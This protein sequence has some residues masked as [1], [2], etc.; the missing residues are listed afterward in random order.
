MVIRVRSSKIV[1][2]QLPAIVHRPRL[3]QFIRKNRHKRLIV[4]QGQAAQGKSTLAASCVQTILPETV[5]VNLD[6]EDSDAS[7]LFHVLVHAFKH[8]MEWLDISKLLSCPAIDM[9]PRKPQLRYREWAHVMFD[10]MP[11]PLYIVLDGLDRLADNGS[12]LILLQELLV[13]APEHV[14]FILLSREEPSLEIQKIRVAQQAAVLHNE[15]LAFNFD[16]IRFFF[17]QLNSFDLSFD[18]LKRIHQITEGWAGGVVLISEHLDHL[19]VKDRHTYLLRQ[20]PIRF[21]EAVFQYFLEEVLCSQPAG[22][23]EFLVR[24]SVFDIIE[25]KLVEHVLKIEACQEFLLELNRK[26]LF[27]HSRFDEE[28]G[29]E[30]Q[31]HQLFKEFLQ[32]KFQVQVTDEQKYK[33]YLNSGVFFEE[34]GDYQK[35]IDFYILAHEYGKAAACIE[36]IGMKLLENGRNA[37]LVR[38]LEALPENR[39]DRHPWLVYFQCMAHRFTG[40][41]E[42][43]ER[44][45]TVMAAFRE[46][47]S[48]KGEIQSLSAMLEAVIAA[49]LGWHVLEMYLDQAEQLLAAVPADVRPHEKAFLLSQYGYGHTVRGNLQTG[50]SALEEAFSLAWNFGNQVLQIT[51]ACHMVVNLTAQNKLFSAQKY[52]DMLDNLVKDIVMPEPQV[53]NL[54]AKSILASFRGEASTARQLL[55]SADRQVH[56]HGLTYYLPVVL[57]YRVF[58]CVICNRHAEMN[59]VGNQLFS[60]ANAMENQVMTASAAFFLGL[61]A[62]RSQDFETASRFLAQADRLCSPGETNTQIQWYA[63]KVVGCLVD[64]SQGKTKCRENEIHDALAYF[65]KEACVCLVAETYMAL[66]LIE[67]RRKREDP[68]KKYLSR[69]FEMSLHAEYH[70]FLVL[71]RTDI[72]A[73]C[74]SAL[75]LASRKIQRHAAAFFCQQPADMRIS[76]LE[77]RAAVLWARGDFRMLDQMIATLPVNIREGSPHLIF[78]Q[79]MCRLPVAPEIAM[80]RLIQALDMFEFQGDPDGCFLAVAGVLN[81]VFCQFNGFRNL[82]RILEKADQLEIRFGRPGRPEVEVTLTGAVLHALI[83]RDPVSDTARKWIG[84]GWQVTRQ[85]KDIHHAAPVFLP[86]IL[87]R[88]LQG[89]L[90]GAG[91]LLKRFDTVTPER[92]SP[93]LCLMLQSLKAFHAWLSGDFDAGLQAVEQGLAREKETGI[94]LIFSSFRIQGAASAIGAGRYELAQRFLDQI[95]PVVAHQGMW[96]QGWYHFVCAWLALVTGNSGACRLHASAGFEK[97]DQAGCGM[98]LACG[99]LMM[100]GMHDLFDEKQDAHAHLNRSLALCEKYGVDQCRFMALLTRASILMDDDMAADRAASDLRAGMRLGREQGYRFGFAW[101]SRKMASLCAEALK[102]EIE[103]AYVRSLITAYRLIPETPPLEI[104]EWPWPVSIYCLGEFKVMVNGEAIRFSRK[105]QY[106]PLAMLKFIVARGGRNVPDHAVQDALWPDSDGNAAHNAF[107]TTLHRLRNLLAT[108]DVLIHRERAL[109]CNVRMV[110]SDIWAF[111]HVCRLIEQHLDDPRPDDRISPILDELLTLYRGAFIPD[112]PAEW[113]IMERQR[114][115]VLFVD[116][117]RKTAGRFERQQRWHQAIRCYRQALTVEAVTEVF[118]EN[119]MRIHAKMGKPV[120]ALLVY[121]RYKA[122]LRARLGMPP[123]SRLSGL[124]RAICGRRSGI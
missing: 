41:K 88:I 95:T 97:F 49:G 24:S 55:D 101:D 122:V 75:T 40:V 61:N 115:Q 92:I 51:V 123:S 96:V 105:P 109:S 27:V 17:N 60:L 87:L 19:S 54:A 108:P 65:K 83:F 73:V 45:P 6:R 82:D 119:L 121:R 22:M 78:W 50:Y 44:L 103:P 1:P 69:G 81:A 53:L 64:L 56:D 80:K 39:V 118:Y 9:G 62:Y 15:D 26:N 107:T 32:S 34:T 120:E 110:W 12:A 18:A 63:G 111:E 3:E 46:Q 21:R 86:M 66:F 117:I 79:G 33:I 102:R 58:Y 67:K 70:H 28:K 35:A 8:C 85:V 36:K 23:S 10:G 76:E 13:Q 104:R 30:F 71:S 112:D 31:Y 100:A 124:C 14:H 48:I 11:D 98:A 4:I 42:N 47:N 113:A 93:L 16:E 94:K 106:K 38:W 99:H 7:H 52:V 59:V 91:H 68:A 43:L 37:D 29:W 20:V 2:P 5:W 89:N 84:R 77:R 25:P 72:I 74:L 57:M 116:I 114:L 90:S